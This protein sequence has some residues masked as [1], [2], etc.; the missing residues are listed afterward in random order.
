MSTS[1]SEKK[2]NHSKGL[3]PK[4]ATGHAEKLSAFEKRLRPV[5]RILETE[6]YDV[7]GCSPIYAPDGKVHVFYSRWKNEFDHLGWVAACEVGHAVADSAE[8]PFTHVD[9]ALKGAGGEAWD[10]WSIHNPTVHKVGDKYAMFYMGSDGSQLGVT[11]EEIMQMDA[12]EYMPYFH[13]LVESKRV[14]LA[15]ADDLNGPWVR[16]GEAPVVDTG[17]TP[18]WDDFCTSNPAF[19]QHP[20]GQCWLYYKAWDYD[21]F[22][23][24]NGNRKYGIAI[25][26]SIEGPYIKYEGNPV[27]DFSGIDER[28]QCED[29]YFW[30]E[31]GEFHVILRDMGF[32]NHEYGLIMHSK[33]GIKWENPEISYKD[34]PTYFD[35]ILPGLDREGRFERPQMLLKN[36][37]PDYLFCAYR[38]GKYNTSSGVVLRIEKD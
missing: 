1:E 22:N 7:W 38:G 25:A 10:S 27:I 26:D 9:V 2:I 36:G 35:E 24:F 33:D 32:Y 6:G 14:G 18:N 5:G 3:E 23:R 28:M 29:G 30:H 11:L 15:L 4:A 21:T 12:D 13:K 34:A 16:V 31:D 8:G 19:M 37:K 17:P 20:N